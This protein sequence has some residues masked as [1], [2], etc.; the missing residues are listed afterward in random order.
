MT[1]CAQN[2]D[3]APAA[4]A[5]GIAPVP[6]HGRPKSHEASIANARAQQRP[7]TIT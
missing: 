6:K 5:N 2:I 1:C 4:K 3:T 7:H